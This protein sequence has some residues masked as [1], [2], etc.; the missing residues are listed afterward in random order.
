MFEAEE[1]MKDENGEFERKL[2]TGSEPEVKFSS[3]EH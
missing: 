3:L 2:K 1:N